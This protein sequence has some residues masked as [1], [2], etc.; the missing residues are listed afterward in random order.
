ML[1]VNLTTHTSLH[2]NQVL[3]YLNTGSGDN[4]V[5]KRSG[6]SWLSCISCTAA[7]PAHFTT[8]GGVSTTISVPFLIGFK[9]FHL[10]TKSL[11]TT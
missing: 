3:T 10:Q 9:V 2:T 7:A 5:L 11:S 6:D 4:I 8:S 1:F